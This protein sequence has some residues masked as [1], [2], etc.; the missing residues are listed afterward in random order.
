[1]AEPAET[2]PA[3]NRPADALDSSRVAV[4]VPC[5]DE[6]A[7]I[8]AVVEEFRA[9]LP[10]A[11]I[12]VVDNASRDA[13]AREATRAGAR[14]VAESRLGKG[15]AL[16][17]G[18]GCAR[19]ADL[20]V[21]VDGDG[22]YRTHDVLEL[23]ERARTSGADMVIGTRLERSE[24]GAFRAGHTLG[25]QLFGWLVWI[26]FGIRTDDLFSG[27]RV[28]TRRFLDSSPLV[29]EG[30]EVEV[31]LSVQASAQGFRVVEMPVS[32][33]SRHHESRSKLRTFRDGY[34]ILRGL[35]LFFRDYRPLAFFGWLAVALLALSLLTG[36]APVADYLRTGLVHRFPRAILAAALF[37][38]AALSFTSGVLLSSIN[39][40]AAELAALIRKRSD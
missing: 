12:L 3:P 17:T 22:T 27:Y 11:E 8:G 35:L 39:R 10:E 13:T 15:F 30:F 38:L 32:Y 37:I 7:T 29:A 14:V 23:L 9:I 19:D 26:L 25:N 16:L 36:Y 4:V 1:M 5:H 2:S 34:R 33:R 31:E 18:F 21:M 20:Y 40:R 28:L 6:E 24:E